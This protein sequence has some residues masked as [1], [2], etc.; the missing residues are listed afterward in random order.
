MT[1]NKA[2]LNV[3]RM[4]NR[5]NMTRAEI[6]AGNK[7]KYGTLNLNLTPKARKHRQSK[8]DGHAPDNNRTLISNKAKKQITSKIMKNN[9]ES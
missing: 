7:P 8:N 9:C 3:W 1:L 6:W 4:S 2:V 5:D